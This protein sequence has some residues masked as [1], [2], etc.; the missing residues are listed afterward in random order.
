MK[1]KNTY[2]LVFLFRVL[3]KSIAANIF[4]VITLKTFLFCLNERLSH[5]QIFGIAA[6]EPSPSRM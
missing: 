3:T 4:T 5:L 2:H 1:M 6:P